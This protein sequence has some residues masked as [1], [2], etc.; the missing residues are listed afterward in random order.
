MIAGRLRRFTRPSVVA[1]CA[2]LGVVVAFASWFGRAW[3]LGLR[4]IQSEGL[5]RARGDAVALRSTLLEPGLGESPF[6]AASFAP[7]SS[8]GGASTPPSPWRTLPLLPSIGRVRLEVARTHAVLIEEIN[9]PRGEWRAGDIDLFT[10]FGAPGVPLAFDAHLVSVPEGL[11][12]APE[13][14]PGD[15]LRVDRATH[16]PRQAYLLLGRPQMAGA[17]IRLPGSAFDRA[18]QRGSM[19]AVRIRSLLPLPQEDAQSGREFVVRLGIWGGTPL[20]LARVQVVAVDPAPRIER[21]Q[22]ILCGPEAEPLPLSVAVLPRVAPAVAPVPSVIAPVLAVR[23]G[24]D[25]LCVR[26]WLAP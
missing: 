18:T 23:H 10:S 7:A 21:A 3:S 17:I 26:V 9:L 6:G 20:T 2:V 16:C 15:N 22:A 24:S 5:A 14:T 19:A 8:G 12:E 25:D 1:S 4:D 11:L 13:G